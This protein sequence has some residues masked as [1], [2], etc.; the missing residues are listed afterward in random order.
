MY[1]AKLTFKFDSKWEMTGGVYDDQVVPEQNL[2]MECPVHDWN[3][4]QLFQAFSNFMY[5]MGH[6]EL[7]IMKGACSVAFSDMRS[8]ENMQKV[9]EEYDLVLSEDLPELINEGIEVQ[10]NFSNEWES[11]YWGYKKNAEKQIRDLKAKISRMENPDDPQYT[12]EEMDAMCEDAEEKNKNDL[13]KRLY[14]ANVVC[15][16]CG[17]KYG[18]Y[19]VGCSSRWEANCNVCGQLKSVT[20]ARDYGFLIKGIKELNKE[21]YGL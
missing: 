4:S 18:K 3:T 8:K 21:M 15:R 5:A 2:T 10:K 12:E 6:S 7:G 20:E 13:L 9:A 1:T 17:E 16:D 19:S 11:R 14:A